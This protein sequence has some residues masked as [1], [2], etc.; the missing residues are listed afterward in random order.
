MKILNIP[1]TTTAK[2][3]AE[4]PRMIAATGKTSVTKKIATIEPMTKYRAIYL[5]AR[6]LGFFPDAVTS[7]IARIDRR[8]QKKLTNDMTPPITT[9]P[10]A[11]GPTNIAAAT[12]PIKISNAIS[13]SN[14]GSDIWGG[15]RSSVVKVSI[16]SPIANHIFYKQTLVNSKAG[17]FYGEH[18]QTPGESSSSSGPKSGLMSDLDLSEGNICDVMRKN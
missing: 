15:E 7:K 13:R 12:A 6:N 5:T 10:P 8:C 18:C 17:G 4:S 11:R 16:S 2:A 14:R 1:S 9:P 3:R